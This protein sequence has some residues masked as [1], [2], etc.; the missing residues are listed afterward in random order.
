M[1]K[2]CRKLQLEETLSTC[3]TEQKVLYYKHV[4]QKYYLHFEVTS[5]FSRIFIVFLTSNKLRNFEMTPFLD[6]TNDNKAS[7]FVRF[8]MVSKAK[9]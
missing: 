3:Q 9:N 7:L 6:I 1:Q 5:C 2:F 4:C 8:F